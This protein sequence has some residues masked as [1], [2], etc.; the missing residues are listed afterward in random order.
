L[1]FSRFHVNST[2]NKLGYSLQENDKF[3]EASH[4]DR[5]EQFKYINEQVKKFSK[6]NFPVI[7]VDTKKKE[8][9]GNYAN[10]GQEWRKKGS[11]RKVNGHDFPEPKG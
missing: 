6:D 3:L 9:I 5:D 7:S 4:P 8:L 2:S 11:P 1:S 10:K